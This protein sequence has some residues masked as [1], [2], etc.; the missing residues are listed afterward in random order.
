MIIKSR[1]D[2]DEQLATS[3]QHELRIENAIIAGVLEEG[4]Q[5]AVN[6]RIGLGMFEDD[7]R[8]GAAWTLE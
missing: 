2:I 6:C 7:S 4:P 3:T 1:I 8:A 5:P